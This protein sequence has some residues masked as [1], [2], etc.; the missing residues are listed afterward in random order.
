VE[1]E[2]DVLFTVEELAKLTPEEIEDKVNKAIYHDDYKWNKEKGYHY[3][4]G[5]KGAENLEN[6]LFWCPRCKKQHV[7]RSKGNTIFCEACG[8]GATLQDTYELVPF[9]DTCVIPETQTAWFNMQREVIKEEVRAEDFALCERVKIGM[10][11]QYGY[12]KNQATSEI[13]GEGELRLDKTGLTYTGTKKGEAWS[14]HIDIKNVP[15]YGMCTDLS[16]FYT[17]FEGKFVEFFPERDIVEKFFLATE[18]L[19]RLHGGK[20]QD[21]K[22]E[23]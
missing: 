5:D 16:R 17:F 3:D 20:W 22:F 23:K 18:E 4:I 12:L 15:T 9:D 13:V 7:M 10:L 21:F 8:N 11:P 1:V 2:F 19:H 6:L 14:F